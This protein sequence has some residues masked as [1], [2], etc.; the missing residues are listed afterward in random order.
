MVQQ[1]ADCSKW[2][3]LINIMAEL[4]SEEGC[5]WDREQDHQTLKRYL[6]EETYEVLDAIDSG[7][8]EKLADELGDLLLQVVFHAQLEA[9]AGHFTINEVVE[10]INSKMI[11]RHPHVFGPQ[12]TRT[13]QEVLGQWERIKATEKTG[14]QPR[15]V[16]EV[17]QNLPALMLAQKVQEKAARVGFDWPDVQGP[18]DKLQEELQELAAA[19][20]PAE[21]EDELGDCLFTLAKLASV[22]QTD[23]EGALRHTV[24]KFIRRFRHVEA[25]MQA[26]NLVWGETALAVMDGFWDE[27]KALETEKEE[28]PCD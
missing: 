9:E 1:Q 5:P 3:R 2:Q 26:E 6:V 19:Q 4:R 8:P 14:G 25:R 28:S 21:R 22:L 23:A 27:A 7:S 20:T 12:K 16:M 17:N 11:R 24:Q 10:A 13:S 18:W 15:G